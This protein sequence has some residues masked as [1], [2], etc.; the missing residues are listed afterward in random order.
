MLDTQQAHSLLA[1]IM[2]QRKAKQ[3]KV[4][5]YRLHYTN[6]LGEVSGSSLGYTIKELMQEF[7]K[8]GGSYRYAFITNK[9]SSKVFRA[10][11]RQLSGKW[12]SMTRGKKS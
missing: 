6:R 11:D 1:S 10:F 5:K 2:E 9:D 7:R 3:G 4:L 8:S 12:V